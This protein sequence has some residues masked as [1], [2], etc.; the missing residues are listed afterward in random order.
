MP[1]SVWLLRIGDEQPP[2]LRVNTKLYNEDLCLLPIQ[3]AIVVCNSF[4]Y[5]FVLSSCNWGSFLSQHID[6]PP[7]VG[8]NFVCLYG[9]A[10]FLFGQHCPPPAFSSHDYE[11]S[12]SLDREDAPGSSIL[13]IRSPPIYQNHPTL[14]AH[15]PGCSR[16]ALHFTKGISFTRLLH[17]FL[18]LIFFL[19]Y[20][21]VHIA[22]S[23]GL[24]SYLML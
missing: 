11:W 15:E 16:S 20:T 10:M 22:P 17:W 12:H 5:S 3:Y 23:V 9:G 6:Q 18:Y 4:R 8:I 1:R 19:H 13:K 14:P 7:L 2:Q 24:H 21:N